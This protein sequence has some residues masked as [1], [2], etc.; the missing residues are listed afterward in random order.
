[1]IAFIEEHRAEIGGE[2]ICRELPIAPSTVYDHLARR[3][4]PEP[5]ASPQS[6]ASATATHARAGTINGLY[7]AEVI[8]RRGPWRSFDAVEYAPLE[9]GDGFNTRRLLEPVG[10]IPPA[11]AEANCYAAPETQTMAAQLKSISLRQTRAGSR[12]LKRRFRFSLQ[13][14]V[15]IAF[16]QILKRTHII[17]SLRA[18]GSTTWDVARPALRSLANRTMLHD[19]T[20][21]QFGKTAAQRWPV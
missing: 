18:C 4:D 13:G 21:G 3:A 6:A 5:A 10:N 1:M 8:H 15:A 12:R 11:A 20:K 2:P 16:G 14:V 7:K 19:A 9:W 17:S